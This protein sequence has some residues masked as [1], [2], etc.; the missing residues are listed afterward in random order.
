MARP[1][2]RLTGDRWSPNDR[3]LRGFPSL[4]IDR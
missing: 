3:P 4:V 1:C 2:L